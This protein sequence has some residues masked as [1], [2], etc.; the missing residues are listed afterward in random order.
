M[1]KK[2]IIGFL[3]CFYVLIPVANSQDAT[4]NQRPVYWG[5]NIGITLYSFDKSGISTQEFYKLNGEAGLNFII[6][7]NSKGFLKT[8][9][10]VSYKKSPFLDGISTF[11]S[12]LDAPIMISVLNVD[13]SKNER[14]RTF[15][16]LVG[17]KLALLL[18]HGTA[19]KAD[20]I[21]HLT[22]HATGDYIKLSLLSEISFNVFP[23]SGSKAFQTFGLR[24]GKDF[25]ELV[26]KFDET[27]KPVAKYLTGTL[28]Y[29]LLFSINKV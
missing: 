28:F 4:N 25:E 7:I 21:Y 12:F 8:G 29:S 23:K 5:G 27:T 24:L 17:S 3:A 15:N 6:P 22:E 11:E 18:E 13:Q 26:F 20:E 16:M 9:L 1:S 10:E 19:T 2:S 14:K